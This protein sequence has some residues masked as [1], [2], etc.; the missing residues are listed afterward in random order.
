MLEW[1]AVNYKIVNQFFP[2]YIWKSVFRKWLF[3]VRR[4]LFWKSFFSEMS[5]INMQLNWSDVLIRIQLLSLCHSSSI[6]LLELN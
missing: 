3:L 2:I 6:Y 4:V 1:F 5:S